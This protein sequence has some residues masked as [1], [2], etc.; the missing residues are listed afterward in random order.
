MT[1]R[2]LMLA[3]PQR[4]TPSRRHL[5]RATRL[6]TPDADE[7]AVPTLDAITARASLAS[8]RAEMLRSVAELALYAAQTAAMLADDGDPDALGAAD[9]VV[10]ALDRARECARKA[11]AA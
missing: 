3:Q 5:V 11:G 2:R 4:A 8:T 9:D 1:A 10:A 6:P 7:V